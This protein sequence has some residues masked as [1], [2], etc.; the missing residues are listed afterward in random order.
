[1]HPAEAGRAASLDGILSA[2]AD[3]TRRRVVDLLSAGER[4]AGELAAAVSASRP[5][6]SRH[7]KI[8][9]LEGLVDERRGA[10]DAR[11]RVFRL[12]REPFEALRGWL[13]E[14]ESFWAG[15][16]SAFERHV[17]AREEDEP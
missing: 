4:S 8:L 12:Q 10:H 14:V 11:R 2:L 16:L 5:A 9:R 6:M 15:Q 13:S 7:L 1:M 3:P 17:A